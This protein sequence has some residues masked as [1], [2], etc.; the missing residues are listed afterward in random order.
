MGDRA[1]FQIAVGLIPVLLFGGFLFNRAYR[2]Q[3]PEKLKLSHG[4]SM[5]GITILGLWAITAESI[6]ISGAVGRRGK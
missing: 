2:P 5:I 1:F 3:W 6:A 4:L